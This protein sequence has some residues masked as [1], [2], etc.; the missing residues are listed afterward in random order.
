MDTLHVEFFEF[1]QGLSPEQ[2]RDIWIARDL[3]FFHIERK[4]QLLYKV[5]L[6]N[7]NYVQD[8]RGKTALY[9]SE[10]EATESSKKKELTDFKVVSVNRMFYTACNDRERYILNTN[11]QPVEFANESNAIRMA[12]NYNN[13]LVKI[14]LAFSLFETKQ[15]ISYEE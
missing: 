7:G 12:I 5:E 14:R 9:N 2:I 15:K 13:D 3:W 1:Q 8:E 11:G 4:T 10:A 6:S